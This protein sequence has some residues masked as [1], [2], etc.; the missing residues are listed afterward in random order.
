MDSRTIVPETDVDRFGFRRLHPG[1]SVGTAS[2][3]YAGWLGQIYSPERYRGKISSRTKR[4]GGRSFKEEVLPIESVTEYFEHFG[5]LEI[6]FTFYAWLVDGEGRPTRTYQVLKSYRDHL[7]NQDQVILKVPQALC[8]QKLLRSGTYAPNAGYLDTELFMR[9]F[10]EPAVNLLGPTLKAMVFEQEYQRKEE[11]LPPDALATSLDAFFSG[12]PRDGRYH[13]ELRTESYLSKPV[14]DVLE[15]HG[16]GQV[17]SHWTWLPP[18]PKQLAQAGGRF[19]NSGRQAVVRLMTP[20]G[21]RYEDAYGRAHPF[22]ALVAGL[23]QPHMVDETVQLME[24]A[25]SQDIHI[26]VIINNRSGGNA[27]HIAR[28][29]ANRFMERHQRSGPGETP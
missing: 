5:T 4:V 16:V 9:S 18:L 1:V 11:R 10:Y 20:R 15:K 2:D 14:F 7:R 13:V 17:L 25:L 3:R 22:N 28:L 26:H 29:I 24:E 21:V 8:A 27:P 6:D 12:V 19:F 23:F